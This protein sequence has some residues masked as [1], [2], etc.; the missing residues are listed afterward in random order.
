MDVLRKHLAGTHYLVGKLRARHEAGHRKPLAARDLDLPPPPPASTRAGNPTRRSAKV[1]RVHPKPPRCSPSG[2]AKGF[3]PPG[4]HNLPDMSDMRKRAQVRL[5]APAERRGGFGTCG[6]GA[7]HYAPKILNPALPAAGPDHL[8]GPI[9][10]ATDPTFKYNLTFDS[11]HPVGTPNTP[12]R[13]CPTAPAPLLRSRTTGPG[14]SRPC[15]TPVELPLP[16]QPMPAR[17]RRPAPLP[18][19]AHDCL[20]T[21]KDYQ[22]TRT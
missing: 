11:L 12:G 21:H 15:L 22:E 14:D 6:P 8:T 16:A 4:Q 3:D 19:M 10:A 7:G 9:K 20:S 2:D 13:R 1:G 5:A 17:R 18:T